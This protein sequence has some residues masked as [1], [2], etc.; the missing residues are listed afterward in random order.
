MTS[1]DFENLLI[2]L[3]SDDRSVHDA[4]RASLDRVCYLEWPRSY[5][6]GTEVGGHLDAQA[7]YLRDSVAVAC[8]LDGLRRGHPRVRVYAANILWLARE[9]TAIPLLID[10]LTAKEK[11][12]RSAS[13]D[14]LGHLSDLCA[15]EPLILLLSDADVDVRSAA[16]AGLGKLG[17]NRAVMALLGQ[18]RSKNWRDR[19]C[20]LYGLGDCLRPHWG[21][22]ARPAASTP[23]EAL[24]T[25]RSALADP[26]QSVRKA[27]LSAYDWN[28]RQSTGR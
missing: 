4:A 24:P 16:A 21:H 6:L 9:K 23:A 25:I 5:M 11:E 12:V 2:D 18:L 28:R 10:C 1:R 22:A 13:A 3:S 26:H 27:A 14:A 20:A 7:M 19:H 15:V 17:D 8:L